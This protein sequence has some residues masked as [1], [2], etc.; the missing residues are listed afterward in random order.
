MIFDQLCLG[1]FK[2]K[3]IKQT[4]E[5]DIIIKYVNLFMKTCSLPPVLVLINTKVHENAQTDC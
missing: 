2:P 4:P 3:Y 5:N 1:F